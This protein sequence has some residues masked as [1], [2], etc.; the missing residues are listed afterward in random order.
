MLLKNPC[1]G[2]IIAEFLQSDNNK[3][4]FLT[5]VPHVKH[6]VNIWLPVYRFLSCSNFL[7]FFF[8]VDPF[9]EANKMCK[10]SSIGL[11]QLCHTQPHL[12]EW[13][14]W[15]ERTLGWLQGPSHLFLALNKYITPARF[16]SW[17][18][19]LHAICTLVRHSDSTAHGCWQQSTSGLVK[20][21]K[22]MQLQEN[23]STCSYTNNLT[24][25]LD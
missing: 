14:G 11:L 12:T 23:L 25:W 19:K 21:F 4:N 13:P 17:G 20:H 18:G 16:S 1:M 7:F 8:T 15:S 3:K 5:I 24:T 9:P 10:K 6:E 22:L 2:S